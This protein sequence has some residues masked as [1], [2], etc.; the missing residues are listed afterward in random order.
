MARIIY[1]TSEAVDSPL[2]IEETQLLALDKVFDDFVADRRSEEADV[3]ATNPRTIVRLKRSIT[4]YLVGGRTVKSD[5]FADAI[6]QLPVGTE[7]PLGFRAH[8]EIGRVKASVSLTKLARNVVQ[9]VSPTQF[10]VLQ[11][12]PK[13]EFSVEPSD[14]QSAPDLF[15]ALQ[16]WAADLAPSTSLRV[17]ARYKPAFIILLLLWLLVGGLLPSFSS[18]AIPSRDNYAEYQDEARNILREGVNE[19]NQRKAIE[20]ILAI[21]SRN[22]LEERGFNWT[23]GRTYWPRY[24]LGAVILFLLSCSPSVVIGIWKGKLKLKRWRLWM[25]WVAG[26]APVTLVL[27]ILVPKILNML[28]L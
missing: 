7:E 2:L 3:A 6:K 12:S 17:W 10:Q 15:G 5:R 21:A 22:P 16:N 14:H 11:E 24:V 8:L 1:P 18:H 28:G 23:P 9:P 27:T 25:K 4:I 26:G 19:N 13:L 20:I